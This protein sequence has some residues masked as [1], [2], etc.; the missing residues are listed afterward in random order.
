MCDTYGLMLSHSIFEV[1]KDTSLKRTLQRARHASERCPREP[2]S[3]NQLI[4]RDDDKVLPNGEAWLFYD[5]GPS[6]DRILMFATQGN[7]RL[8]EQTEI[9]F[10][11]GT[12]KCAPSRLFSQLYTIHGKCYGVVLPLLYCLLPNKRGATYRTVINTLLDKV[13]LSPVEWR[14]DFERAAIMLSKK[15]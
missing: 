12:F 11:D 8:L 2:V 1:P 6:S 10:S 14:T 3:L 7:L 15:K 4:L 9:A 5:S 13:T